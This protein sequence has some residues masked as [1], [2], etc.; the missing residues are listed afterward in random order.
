MAKSGIVLAVVM[1]FAF[2]G[3]TCSQESVPM[4][5]KGFAGGDEYVVGKS[6]AERVFYVIYPTRK[7]MP[8]DGAV[9]M[10]GDF[11]AEKQVR[12][13]SVVHDSR[14]DNVRYLIGRL[15]TAKGE[16]RIHLLLNV[17]DTKEEITQIRIESL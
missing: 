13:F 4:I 9:E 15:V 12:D 3:I 17:S 8:R 5:K 6:M 2:G 10:L 14:Q 16:Y 11:F 1:L 7:M